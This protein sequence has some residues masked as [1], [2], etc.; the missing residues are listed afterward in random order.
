MI[1]YKDIVTGDEM[2]SDSF[3][4]QDINEVVFEVDCTLMEK[5]ANPELEIGDD[6]EDEDTSKINNIANSFS[7]QR[8]NCNKESY[9]RYIKGYFRVVVEKLKKKNTSEEEIQ[10]F[11][12]GASAYVKEQILPHFD[13]FK[14]YTGAAMDPE[15]MLALLRYREEGVTPYFTFWKHGL[16]RMEV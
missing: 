12:K 2:I 4:I 8:A 16:E 1:I 14:L 6:E 9:L 10:T 5:N 15:G 11:Q 7:L 13:D 3:K